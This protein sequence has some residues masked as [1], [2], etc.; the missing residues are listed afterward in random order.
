[1]A[2][3]EVGISTDIATPVRALALW[4]SWINGI[5]QSEVLYGPDS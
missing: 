2:H 3:L 5:V 1:M 4:D